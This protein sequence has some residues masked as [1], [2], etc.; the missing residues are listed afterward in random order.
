MRTLERSPYYHPA[1]R[2]LGEEAASAGDRERACLYLWIYDRL[3]K[4]RSADHA[5]LGA[6]CGDRPPSLPAG[7]TMPFYGTFPLAPSDAALR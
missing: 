5:R 3:F 4:G 6:L 1:I 2:L 7:V